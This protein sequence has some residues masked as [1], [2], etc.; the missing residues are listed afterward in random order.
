VLDYLRAEHCTVKGLAD[1][2]AEC[3]QMIDKIKKRI[4]AGH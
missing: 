3:R 2:V 4:S 1:A